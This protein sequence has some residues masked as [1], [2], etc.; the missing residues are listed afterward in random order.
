MVLV[1]SLVEQ[2]SDIKI[3]D[4]YDWP[5]LHFTDQD[6]ILDVVKYLTEQS[7]YSKISD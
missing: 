5:L 7:P 1:K 3:S 4:K 2:A 6:S